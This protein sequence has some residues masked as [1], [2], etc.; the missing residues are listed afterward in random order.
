MKQVT[1]GSS[2]A[3]I[4]L[5]S[6]PLIY[7][8]S[9]SVGAPQ[10]ACPDETIARKAFNTARNSF[11]AMELAHSLA[12]HQKLDAAIALYRQIIQK[13]PAF[14]AGF[15]VYTDLGHALRKQGKLKE[16]IAAYQAAIQN[17][18]NPQSA[19]YQSLSDILRQ[20]GRGKEADAVL[21]QR[22]TFDPEGAI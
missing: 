4:A 10:T 18:A 6:L 3:T 22:P 9:P 11:A 7:P 2:L 15:D 14:A 17:H 1:I 20:Q 12:C 13:D 16:A 19:S 5:F 21:K 8:L